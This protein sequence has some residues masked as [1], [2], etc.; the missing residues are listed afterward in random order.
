MHTLFAC[1]GY[2]VMSK[3]I[4]LKYPS[5]STVKHIISI[6]ILELTLSKLWVN[7]TSTSAVDIV[8]KEH[9]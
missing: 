9:I 3:A 2:S 1:N 6:E 7:L 4:F 5:S 8:A